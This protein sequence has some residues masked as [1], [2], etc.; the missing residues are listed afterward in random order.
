MGVDAEFAPERSRT[1]G[2]ALLAKFATRKGRGEGG[3]LTPPLLLSC[4]VFSNFHENRID[5]GDFYGL[6]FRNSFNPFA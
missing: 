2:N 3:T 4:H 1:R 6:A 5:I